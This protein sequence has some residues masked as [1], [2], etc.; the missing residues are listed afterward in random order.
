MINVSVE[1]SC[2]L[3]LLIIKSAFSAQLEYNMYWYIKKTHCVFVY[4]CVPNEMTNGVLGD[5]FL[6]LDQC[7]TEP[8]DSL[9][10]MSDELRY[11]R[12]VLLD[13][14]RPSNSCLHT[15]TT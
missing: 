13:L 10:C 8:L 9:R 3:L 15:L 12:D 6:N 14:V 5:L 7:I 1:K 2:Q 11:P 4:I